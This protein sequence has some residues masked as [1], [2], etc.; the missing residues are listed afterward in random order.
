VARKSHEFGEEPATTTNWI[1]N[2]EAHSGKETDSFQGN[3]RRSGILKKKRLNS[4]R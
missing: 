3:G 1:R 4:K 2:D